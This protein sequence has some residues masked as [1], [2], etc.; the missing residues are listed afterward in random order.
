MRAL[1]LSAL[2]MLS[3]CS[4]AT[5][6]AK[7][8][9]AVALV[10]V[11]PV[12]FGTSGDTVTVYGATEAR[13][14]GAHALVA[15]TESI[16][17]AIAAPNGTSV[18]P[19][20]I[21]ASLRASPT[22][23]LDAVKAAG[24]AHAAN[25]ALERAIRLRNDG[26]G[27]DA[28]VDA[29]RA[30]AASANATVASLHARSGSLVLRAPMA[31]TVEGLAVRPGD[32]IAA[33]TTVAVVAAAGDLRVRFGVDPQMAQR[34]R[35]GQPLKIEPTGGGSAIDGTIVGI[36]PAIDPTTH[37]ASVFAQLPPAY[38]AGPGQPFRAVIAVSGAV[39]A[40]TI[41]YAALLDDGG[42]PYVFVVANGVAHRRDVVPGNST[43]DRIVIV[44]GVDASA[45]VVTEGGTALEDGMHVRLDSGR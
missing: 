19:G 37:L 7:A 4:G 13:A 31:G 36:D 40:L 22:A 35:A 34:I 29:A 1:L 14:G 28:E 42:K 12:A 21:V 25:A 16:V 3:A 8:P 39:S 17:A 2:V 30:S 32:L 26:L 18:R 15:Q 38:A 24:D 5:D 33:G 11:A 10:R 20:Q 6:E 23:R 45:Q 9:A 27:S 43:G 44:R 41:P